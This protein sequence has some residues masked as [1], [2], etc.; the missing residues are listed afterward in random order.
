MKRYIRTIG[1]FAVLLGAIT[2]VILWS[3]SQQSRSPLKVVFIGYT[4]A[5]PEEV[6]ALF[7]VTNGSR[8]VVERNFITVLG[9]GPM[10]PNEQ[11]LR[12]PTK[13]LKPDESEVLRIPVLT[14]KGGRWRLMVNSCYQWR[15][16]WSRILSRIPFF[17]ERLRSAGGNLSLSDWMDS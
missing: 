13:M 2:F 5:S 15:V 4:N 7:T 17:P 14:E 9:T 8:S 6:L 3:N 12:F 16:E 11:L 10:P 1:L